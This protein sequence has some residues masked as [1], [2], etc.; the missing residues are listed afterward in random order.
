MDEKV[1]KFLFRGT[2]EV[3]FPLSAYPRCQDKNVWEKSFSKDSV[4]SVSKYSPIDT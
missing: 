2:N 4:T 1:T 3:I